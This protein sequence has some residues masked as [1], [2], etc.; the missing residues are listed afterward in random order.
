MS[1]YA[2]KVI[3]NLERYRWKR[4]TALPEK[5]VEVNIAAFHLIAVEPGRD[6]LKMNV[7]AGI[8]FKNQTPLLESEISFMNLNPT[9]SVPRSIIE[10]EIYFLIK[11]DPNYF[12]KNN[13]QV[14][15][16]GHVVDPDTIDW[17][18]YKNPKTFPFAVVQDPG[19]ANSLGRIKFMFNNPFSVYLHDTPSKRAFNYTNRGVSH[20]CVRI[21]KPMDFAFFCLTEKDSLYYDR[22]RYSV[23]QPPLSPKGKKLAKQGELTKLPD[24][25]NLKQKIP[26]FI[27]YF[28]IYALPGDE[29]MKLYF[30]DDVYGFDERIVK[31]LQLKK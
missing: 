31:E 9:W 21:Q 13:M 25:V 29:K 24:I 2:D 5:Y 11:K 3:A 30:A 1:Y 27:D 10:K 8:P 18:K 12:K 14:T 22:L 26:L 4:K 6:L 15:R 23:N 16:K 7:C 17:S 20:G 19:D 28:T